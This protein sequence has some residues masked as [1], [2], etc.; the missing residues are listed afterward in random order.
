MAFV[1]AAL[2]WSMVKNRVHRLCSSGCRLNLWI[3]ESSFCVRRRWIWWS[4]ESCR[5][6]GCG[7]DCV[8]ETYKDGVVNPML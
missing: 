5:S 8:V 2:S 3:S 4:P 6:C 7:F 1:I